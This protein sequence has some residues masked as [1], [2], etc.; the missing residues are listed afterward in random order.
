MKKVVKKQEFIELEISGKSIEKWNELQEK[1]IDLISNITEQLSDNK[2]LNDSL[3][4]ITEVAAEYLKAKTLK[5][6]LENEKLISEIKLNY[7]SAKT[8]MAEE[9][10]SKAEL[11][12][13]Q[14]DNFENY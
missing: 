10:K 9:Q 6:T 1:F 14:L 7:A 5:P 2:E 3:K 11:I 12:S 4:G 8:K 13:I